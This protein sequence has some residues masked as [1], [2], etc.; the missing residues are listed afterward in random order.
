MKQLLLILTCGV[1]LT[2]CGDSGAR[3]DAAE[4]K[5]PRI[6]K[7]LEQV[8]LKHWDEAI[9]Q[10]EAALESNRELAC[11]DLE[12]ALIYHQQKKNHVRA[13]YHYERYLE[14]RPD[15]QKT[16]LIADWIRHAKISFAAQIGQSAGDISEDLIR[17]TRENNMLRK[18]LEP[19]KNGAPAVAGRKPIITDPVKPKPPI[20]QPE[21][22]PATKK[23]VR[24]ILPAGPKPRTYKVQPG[25]TLSRI[26]K[27]VYGDS[28]KWEKIYTA[29]QDKMRNENDLK[30]GQTIIIPK[31]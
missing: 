18:Q 27:A 26:A 7:A 12:L 23:P 21:P 31:L 16:P 5:N 1:L 17:L 2:G 19:I 9:R 22:T 4:E 15:S 3:H 14:K 30:A 25:D 20:K 10:F 11:P 8:Q 28:G 24:R 6:Q 29:N 13:I